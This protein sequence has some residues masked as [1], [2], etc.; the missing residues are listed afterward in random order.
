M[1]QAEAEAAYKVALTEYQKEMTE[2]A[3]QKFA[4]DL[5]VAKA[6]AEADIAKAK[7]KAM[8]AEREIIEKANDYVQKLYGYYVQASDA[9]YAL[10]KERSDKNFQL[11]RLDGNLVKVETWIAEKEA[12]LKEKIA[13]KEAKIAVWTNYSG[14]DVATMKERKKAITQEKFSAFKVEDDARIA[15][16]TAKEAMEEVLSSYTAGYNAWD[17]EYSSV[18]VVAA[19]QKAMKAGELSS[20]VEY[21]GTEDIDILLNEAHAL[22]LVDIQD[23]S[24][25]GD[26]WF[27]NNN[28]G[29]MMMVK[30]NGKE[31][32]AT[33]LNAE[34]VLIGEELSYDDIKSVPF[35][36]LNQYAKPYVDEVIENIDPEAEIKRCEEGIKLLEEAIEANKAA[37]TEKTTELDGKNAEK[38]ALLAE[39]EVVRNEI[40][41]I[42]TD[43]DKLYADMVAANEAVEPY[44]A[45]VTESTRIKGK[46]T[47][48]WNYQNNVVNTYKGKKEAATGEKETA[49]G[50]LETLN[51]QLEAAT[52]EEEKARLNEQIAEVTAAIAKFDAAIKRADEKIK[53]AEKSAKDFKAKI[54]AEQK[55]IDDAN[56]E[57]A[58]IEWNEDD[59]ADYTESSM[60]LHLAL[61]TAYEKND[62]VQEKMAPISM[63]IAQLETEIEYLQGYI[64]EAELDIDEYN[65]TIDREKEIIASGID[66]KAVWAEL[67]QALNDDYKAEVEGLKDNEAVAAYIVACETYD[68][69]KDA[70]AA[71]DDELEVL[72]KYLEGGVYAEDVADSKAEIEKLQKQIDN[73]NKQIAEL[74]A[75]D[76]DDVQDNN[77]E[78]I[79]NEIASLEA[80]IELLEEQI[81]IAQARVDKCKATLDAA[82]AALPE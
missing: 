52:T 68:T 13:R 32:P 50:E 30:V 37:V 31:Y 56:A 63:G 11:A 57:I 74:P 71:L 40:D 51:E 27:T 54:D 62:I 15:K 72:N 70:S 2:Q 34:D 21:E 66:L 75:K 9:L 46:L 60:A 14:V 28:G 22:G 41:K 42:N 45:I 12:D 48:E 23:V 7:A 64:A 39:E 53:A 55:K 49:N 3:K 5:E 59:E 43:L 44:R 24:K 82:I 76:K 69:A 67:C 26:R 58:K 61:Q 4:I 35:Y 20:V 10:Y 18:A 1:I 29:R 81:V 79:A 25:L 6:K 19:I 65:V 33:V 73:L 8:A 47:S 36:S 16:E 78:F 17:D 38:E 77:K 80:E